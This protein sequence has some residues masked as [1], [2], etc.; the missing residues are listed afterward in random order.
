MTVRAER[1]TAAPPF[2]VVPLLVL[3]G[4][5]FVCVTG[6]FLPTGLLPELAEGLG[7]S[8]S[9][10]GFLV[11]VYAATVALT[12]PLLTRLTQR[13]PRKALVIVVLC[14]FAVTNVVVAIA[15]NY[16]VMFAARIVGGLAHGL[17]WAV[18]G[19]YAAYLVPREK[20][21][22]AVAITTGGGTVAFVLGVP[23]GTVLGHA[24]GWRLAFLVMA[25]A[26]VVF[27]VLVIAVLPPVSH[28]VQLRTGEIPIPS[29]RDPT[30]LA[31]VVVCS[32]VAVMIIGQNIFYTYVVPFLL[33]EVG[34]DD[35]AIGGMLFAYG[36][37]GAV[38]LVIVGLVASKYPR[39]SLPV[40]FGVVVLSL[41]V[42]G[43]FPQNLPLVVAAVI[44]WGVAFGC[45]PVLFHTRVLQE[46][47]VRI[48]DLSAA[49]LTVAFNVGIGGG[50]LIGGLILDRAGV[51]VLP[52][53]E[54]AVIT[55]G[56]VLLLLSDRML[57]RR[58]V[59][60]R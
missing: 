3:A 21:A 41:L 30:M 52:F 35:G 40:A 6:E 45:G 58:A 7:V 24:L 5:I 51:G 2:P 14:T 19:A 18:V 9:S 16:E 13:F 8:Q 42:I 57:H 4:A 53:V 56:I 25:G 29:R 37:A 33:E 44:V 10:I 36:A 11:T 46:A 60:P 23:I 49:W 32:I 38:S 27:T 22:K 17:F 26:V 28:E 15:P 50:A 1:L 47:S 31:V 48:R 39:A 12:A 59:A 34:L 43:L 54:A 20:L 55:L